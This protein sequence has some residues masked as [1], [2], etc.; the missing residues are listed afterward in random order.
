L[1][2]S[3]AFEAFAMS[4]PD[5]K[6]I[7]SKWDTARR[8]LQTAIRLWFTSGDP[9]SIHTLSAAAYE[10]IHA[11]SKKRDPNR[12]DLLFDSLIVKEE[13]RS[14][15]ARV[16]KE[17]ANF[18]KHAKRD[19]EDTATIEYNPIAAE[20]FILFS[21]LGVELCREAKSA[22]ENA[23]IYWLSF[24]NPRFLTD[25]GREVMIDRL[26]VEV[27]QEI[28]SIPKHEFLEGFRKLHDQ[29]R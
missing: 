15:W 17:P 14:D 8:Q 27:I 13:F 29:L 10:I 1:L 6:I 23:Y 9:V 20:A 4:T 22:E 2:A 21:I 12:R 25:K 11:I 24:H 7:I 5:G 28:Q 26:P 18:F 19:A 16:V 3:S